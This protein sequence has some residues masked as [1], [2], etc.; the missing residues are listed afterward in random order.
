M[1]LETD[2]ERGE[3]KHFNRVTSF[4]IQANFRK[5]YRDAKWRSREKWRS[6]RL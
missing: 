5:Q 6:R 3:R 1:W 4:L 2:G